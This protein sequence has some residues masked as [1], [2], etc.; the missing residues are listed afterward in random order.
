MCTSPTHRAA[1]T[2]TH[3]RRPSPR[4]ADAE[5]FG[6]CTELSCSLAPQLTAWRLRGTTSDE[7]R[8]AGGKAGKTPGGGRATTKRTQAGEA[9]PGN[10][11]KE[12]AIELGRHD[13]RLEGVLR[14]VQVHRFLPWGRKGVRVFALVLHTSRCGSRSSND[15]ALTALRPISPTAGELA[16]LT[17]PERALTTT[18]TRAHLVGSAWSAGSGRSP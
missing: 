3:A 4:A 14:R 11:V 5:C 12:R 10:G 15:D 6:N 16:R 1:E 9:W 7:T 2:R 8:A 18:L 13:R 17:K